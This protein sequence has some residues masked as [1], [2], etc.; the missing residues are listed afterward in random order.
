MN[1]LEQYIDLYR[2]NRDLIDANGA[3]VLNALRKDAC[4]LLEKMRL[5]AKGGENFENIDLNALLATDYGLNLLK[6]DID[7]DPEKTFHC[8]V[9]VSS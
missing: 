5:P 1:A 8:D 6:A 7:F 9:P 4:A 2:K 3:P